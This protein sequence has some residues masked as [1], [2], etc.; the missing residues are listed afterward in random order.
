MEKNEIFLTEKGLQELREEIKYLESIKRKEI[1][2]EIKRALEYGDLSENAEYQIAS[3]HQ[4]MNEI[5][6]IRLRQKL[7]KVKIVEEKSSSD[8]ICIG[9]TVKLENINSGKLIEY[10][11]VPD[12]QIDFT[13][14]KISM[15]SPLGSAFTGKH[16]GEQ[17][18]IELPVGIMKYK[19]LKILK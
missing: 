11:F 6:I 17:V 3:E 10:I 13:K 12:D 2:E 4:R 5:K 8:G 16:E 9:S 18:E 1:Q 7:S 14:N 19:I 15:N